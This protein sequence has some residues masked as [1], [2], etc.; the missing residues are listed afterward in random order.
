MLRQIIIKNFAIFK[1]ASIEPG[2][3][4]NVITGESGAGKSVVVNALS[5]I[6]GARAYREMI[7]TGHDD[8]VVEAIFQIPA[9]KRDAIYAQHGIDEELLVIT[10]RIFLEKPSECRLNGKI[11]PLSAITDISSGLI[12]IH[13]QYEN[14]S[15]LQTENHI[16]YLDSFAGSE[17]EEALSEYKEA[18]SAYNDDIKY[19]ISSSGSDSERERN[20]EILEFQINEIDLAGLDVIDEPGLLEKKK[21]LE[22]AEFFIQCTRESLKW[23][24]NEENS[25]SSAIK[26]AVKSLKP[27]PESDDIKEIINNLNESYFLLSDASSAI[28]EFSESIVFAPE[29]YETIVDTIENLGKLK[30]K[31]GDTIE[32]ILQYRE[33]AAE[34]LKE[35]INFKKHFSQRLMSIGKNEALL[36]QLG[37]RLTLIRKN[38]AAKLT[39]LLVNELTGMGMK[40]T[41]LEISFKKERSKNPLG[42]TVF[43]DRGIDSCEFLISMNAGLNPMSL[44]KVASGGEMSR[45]MLGFKSVFSHKE[46]TETVV[47]DEID[48]GISG[49]AAIAVA[50]KLSRLSDDRQIICITHLPQIA[51]RAG[52]HYVIKKETSDG[53]SLAV[54]QEIKGR[55]NIIK[56]IATLTDGEIITDEGIG[57]ADKLYTDYNRKA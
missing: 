22:N 25:T 26:E 44:G 4:F 38:N 35:I 51:V 21:L 27:L 11:C 48:S 23:L 46:G 18:L 42:Y 47:F 14:Q 36:E 24:E 55:D 15:L 52:N 45:I 57:H 17:L 8:A 40:E 43:G 12:D 5:L 56:A 29:E 53:S 37:D 31:Y 6:C 16:K 54:I 39:V 1:D 28:R 34:K 9:E 7:R 41:V 50:D 10:R 32:D 3:G 13:G 30:R 33:N 19:I 2:F 20:K 49:N